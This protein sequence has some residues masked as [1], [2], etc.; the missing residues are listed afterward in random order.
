MELIKKN[1]GTWIKAA[2]ILTIGILF[3][4]MGAAKPESSADA[5]NAINIIIGIVLLVVGALS[6]VLAIIAACIAKK[7][8]LAVAVPGAIAIALGISILVAKYAT[9]LILLVLY[10]APYILIAIGALIL[11]DAIFRLVLSAKAKTIK[12]TLFA[13]VIAMIIGLVILT[14]GIL[15]VNG[16]V[17]PGDIQVIILG[18]VLVV[19]ALLQVLFTF[20]KGP[21]AVVTI[22][23]VKSAAKEDDKE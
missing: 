1:L 15:C 16:W 23:G 3:I 8:F 14:A 20:V 22:V 5:N 19:V 2:L 6:L 11:A 17:I 21:E 10:V 9:T 7:G 13:I 12:D 4:V 18:I